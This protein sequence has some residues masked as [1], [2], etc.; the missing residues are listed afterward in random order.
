MLCA[1]AGVPLNGGD[2]A[3]VGLYGLGFV[4]EVEG[5]VLLDSYGAERLRRLQPKVKALKTEK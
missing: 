5:E 4:I 3:V 2:W 1:K